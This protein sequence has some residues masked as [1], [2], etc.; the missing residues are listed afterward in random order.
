MFRSIKIREKLLFPIGLLI[1]VLIGSTFVLVTELTET[2]KSFEALVK[3]QLRARFISKDLAAVLSESGRVA[4]LML[5]QRESADFTAS[6]DRLR[7]TLAL[8]APRRDELAVL[9]PNQAPALEK[10]TQAFASMEKSVK[11]TVDLKLAQDFDGATAYWAANARAA[12][13]PALNAMNETADQL[14]AAANDA[15][16]KQVAATNETIRSTVIALGA[17]I[18]VITILALLIV[19]RGVVSPI[20]Q[21]TTKITKLSTGDGSFDLPEAERGDELGAMGRAL[22]VFRENAE[23][24]KVAMT[25]EAVTIEIGEVIAQAARNDLTVR[26]NLDNKTGFL[27]NIGA[28]INQLVEGS[29]NTLREIG[30]KTRQ[31]SVAVAEASAAVGQV[32]GGAR[33]QNNA[34]GQVTQSLTESA[35]AIRMVSSSV[36]VA[37][38]K[39]ILAANLVE[40]GR[41]SA[42]E[43]SR[44]VEKIAQNSRKISQITQVI[45]GIANRTHIL[46]LNAA[47]EAARA[48][49]H[50]KGF[51]VVAQ[52]VGKLAESAAQNAQQITDIVEQATA[53]AAAGHSASMLVKQT[54]DSIA[55]EVSET[56]QM[57]RSIAVAME[58]Q[59]A[60]VS[61]IEGNVTELRGIAS[62]NA[63]AAEEITATMIQLSQLADDQRKQV[64][65]FKT[66]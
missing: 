16:T 9:A 59:Q 5:L 55:G 10:V 1:A 4:N 52:E 49:E 48:G 13:L 41:G 61:Q 28:Q 53:D 56:S 37:N 46:S 36:N 17:V 22:L 39:G 8:I 58:E 43:L 42:D 32:S 7:S 51:V 27:R 25:A 15:V 57:I 38:D 54:M 21:L 64:D 35:K 26:V 50:G 11:P 33:V 63:V 3:T 62:G 30:Q 29:N 44:I 31:V 20:K 24:I 14:Q 40:R 6:A 12:L 66:K 60:I 65:L 2:N 45:A 18:L 23:K 19:L 47:I 34:V